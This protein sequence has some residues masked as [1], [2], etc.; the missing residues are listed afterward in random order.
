MTRSRPRARRPRRRRRRP[1]RRSKLRNL[2]SG[3]EIEIADVTSFAFDDA[4]KYLAYVVAAPE[5]KGNGLFVRDLAAA[6]QPAVAV[7]QADGARYDQLTWAPEASVLAFVTAPA[8]DAPATLV[9]WDGAARDGP[10]PRHLGPGA[11]R[12]GAAARRTR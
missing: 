9:R 1:A 5:G 12:L 11:R 8:E 10:R 6:G 7:R 4:A 3:D 2:A